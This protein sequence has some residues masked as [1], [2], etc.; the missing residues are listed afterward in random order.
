[1]R[2]SRM[3]IPVA[4]LALF[5]AASLSAQNVRFDPPNPDSRTPITAHVVGPFSPC[6]PTAEQN[7]M[8]LSIHLHNCSLPLSGPPVDLQVDVGVLPAG[9]YDVVVGFAPP[10]ILIGLGSGTLVVQ[11]AAPPLRLTPNIA[12]IGGTQVTLT[13]PMFGPNPAVRFGDAVA[14]VVS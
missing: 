14:T 8:R 12:A 13:G 5:V 10:A 3:R 9:V 6:T 7:G 11:D 2:I 1:M 4:V